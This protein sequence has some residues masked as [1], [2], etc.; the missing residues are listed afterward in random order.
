M[1]GGVDMVEVAARFGA[2]V[3]APVAAELDARPNPEDCF[4]WDLV[5]AAS[6]AGLFLFCPFSAGAPPLTGC[7]TVSSARYRAAYS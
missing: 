7:A 6:A 4:S 5:E 1:N 3:V 2:E